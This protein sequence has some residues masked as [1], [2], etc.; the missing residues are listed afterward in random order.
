[1]WNYTSALKKSS[2]DYSDFEETDIEFKKIKLE[3]TFLV[4]FALE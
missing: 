3:S 1:M 4:R 2:A